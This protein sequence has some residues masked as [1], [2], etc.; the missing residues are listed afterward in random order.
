M[1][2]K[3]SDAQSLDWLRM[4]VATAIAVAGF[5]LVRSDPAIA[6]VAAIAAEVRHG[7]HPLVLVGSP[8]CPK[9]QD[10]VRRIGATDSTC[11]KI[12]VMPDDEGPLLA[13]KAGWRIVTVSRSTWWQLARKGIPCL[14]YEREVG[15]WNCVS[16]DDAVMDML[17]TFELKQK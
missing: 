13:C 9:C 3:S 4:G 17:L 1:S 16:P 15:E 7:K 6:E 14:W 10:A 12:L 2:R 11:D 5:T 8:S